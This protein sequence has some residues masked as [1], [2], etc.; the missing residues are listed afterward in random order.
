MKVGETGT[1]YAVWE[2]V[3]N[4]WRKKKENS[5]REQSSRSCLGQGE[6]LI[7]RGLAFTP[8]YQL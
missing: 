6:K 7:L 1:D 3:Q 2:R 8:S 5:V 4:S